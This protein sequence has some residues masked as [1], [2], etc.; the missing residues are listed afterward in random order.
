MTTTGLP[1]W[2]YGIASVLAGIFIGVS[3]YTFLYAKG[4]SYLSNDPTHCTNCHVMREH[5]DGWQRATHHTFATCNDCHVPSTL[6]KKFY[7]KAENG[8]RH[9]YAFTTQNF[10]EPIEIKPMSATVVVKN[11][12]R[13]H[14][15]MVNDL[16]PAPQSPQERLDCLLCHKSVGHGPT[17]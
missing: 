17:K 4:Y 14:A 11:C 9:S 7:V 6:V 10:H 16:H 8:Y 2:F 13:C 1:R 3:V 5:F 12:V 15:D